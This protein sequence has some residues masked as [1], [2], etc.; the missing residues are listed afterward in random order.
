MNYREVSK[1]LRKLGCVIK[2]RRSG[3]SHRKWIN[4]KNNKIAVIPDHGS[5]DIE[6]GT[7]RNAIKSLGLSWKDFKKA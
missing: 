5:R 1:K 7:L 3:G 6:E 4:P 2:R